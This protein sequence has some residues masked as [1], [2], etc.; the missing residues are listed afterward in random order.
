MEVF[1][2]VCVE[3]FARRRGS[4]VNQAD[5]ERLLS[6]LSYEQDVR[7][8][9]DNLRRAR[10]ETGWKDASIRN[11]NYTAQTL[12]R[13]TW[14]NLGYRFGREFGEQPSEEIEKAYRFLAR[15]YTENKALRSPS[16]Q[17]YEDAFRSLDLSEAH[18]DMLKVHY[19]APERTITATRMANAIG[20]PNYGSANLHYGRLGRLVGESLEFDPLDEH[21]GTLVTFEKRNGEWHWIMRYQVV[22]ALESL[23]WIGSLDMSLPEEI[24]EDALISEGARRRVYVNAYERN[25]EARRR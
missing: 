18:R 19:R 20:Y 7:N 2:D 3:T 23:G 4:D 14:Q 25:P 21:L 12:R 5:H 15:L 10:F 13:L 8:P 24:P 6:Q 1:P 17:Q 16:A 22:R 9:P 11:E